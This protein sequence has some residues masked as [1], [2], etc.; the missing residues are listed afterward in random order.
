M[1]L[2]IPEPMKAKHADLH[3]EMRKACKE[4]GHL[5][6]LAM[7]IGA[8]MEPHFVKEE[9]Y[10]LPPSGC[11]HDQRKNSYSR[12]DRHIALNH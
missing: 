1:E 2:K 6:Q 8:L 7:T 10:A 3:V 4:V 5:G 12:H 9:K 11:C